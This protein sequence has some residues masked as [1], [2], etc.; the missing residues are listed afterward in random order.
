VI[1]WR[2]GPQKAVVAVPHEILRIVYFMLKR[3]EPY[4]G[5]KR[6]LSWRK[7]KRLERVAFLERFP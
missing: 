3:N 6:D 4:R 2:K 5:E 1:F 7:L